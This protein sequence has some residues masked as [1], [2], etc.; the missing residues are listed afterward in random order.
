MLRHL[1]TGLLSLGALALV[2]CAVATAPDTR[3]S[4][5]VFMGAS[6][7]AMQRDDMQ[8]PGMLWVQD[9][10]DLWQ[11]KS[12]RSAVA[13]ADCHGDAAVSMRGVAARY[14]VFDPSGAGPLTLG[15]RI[16]QCRSQRQQAPVLA[17]EARDLLGLESYVAHQSRGLPM[18]A[19][20]DARLAPFVQ[21]GA[22]LFNQR[23]GQLDL[24]CAQCH[25][26]RAGLR[27]GS[28]LIPEAHANGYPIYRL[29]WQGM[30]SLQRR[31]RNCMTGVRAEPFPYGAPELVVLELYLAQRARGMPVETPAVRP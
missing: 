27:L 12:G 22:A 10:A 7:Q 4:G 26:Q 18:A 24:S 21:R 31:M 6:T 28:S 9:G 14:P 15:Q 16:N 3:R 23:M 19:G 25:T 2:A 13:C 11:R 1:R 29:E 30:G 8:N 17:P 20:A 5:F